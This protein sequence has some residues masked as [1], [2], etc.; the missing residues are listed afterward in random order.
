MKQTFSD[1]H[2]LMI[3]KKVVLPQLQKT[4]DV[5][6]YLLEAI[7]SQQLS[8][9]AADTIWK[10]FLQL[11][12]QAYPA[13]QLL[14][15]TETELLRAAGLSQQ[16]ISYLRNVAIFATQNDISIAYID[17]L[18]DDDILKYLTAI[19]GVGKWT[20]EMLLIFGLLREDV[21]PYDDLAIQQAME[22]Y[23]KIEY[24]NKKGLIVEMIKIANSWQPHRSLATRYLWAARNQ[25]YFKEKK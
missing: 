4:E 11:Y 18:S 9:K 14:L 24:Q 12:P 6:W 2:I 19:K 22:Y 13:P 25:N 20:V 7:V 10:R 17:S 16:K 1:A 15:Q 21:F 5:Y 8:V 23:Y 3:S